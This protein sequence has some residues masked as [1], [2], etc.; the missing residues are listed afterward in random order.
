MSTAPT[1]PWFPAATVHVLRR[2][3]RHSDEITLHHGYDAALGELAAFLRGDTAA[4]AALT[5]RPSA[6]RD[7][8]D[9][10]VVM[11]VYGTGGSGGGVDAP[12]AGEDFH[13]GGFTI[14]EEPVSGPEP[15]AVGLRL[16][17]LRVLDGGT[18]QLSVTYCLEAAGL[19]IAVRSGEN[20]YPAVSITPD[21]H[22]S[23]RPITVDLKNADQ[24]AGAI[25]SP[26]FVVIHDNPV[27]F[28]VDEAAFEQWLARSEQ[29]D[30]WLPDRTAEAPSR[31][32][33]GLVEDAL[34]HQV[35]VGDPRLELQINGDDDSESTGYCVLLHNKHGSQRLVGITSGW[36][37]LDFPVD[38][39]TSL[40]D[41]ARFHLDEVR[42]RANWLLSEI[43]KPA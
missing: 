15:A 3:D 42:N 6:P 33:S 36:S 11:S 39:D 43:Q 32:L 16:A 24:R 37:D 30:F 12:T 31:D 8:S 19:S 27:P 7:L 1:S 35:L 38:K 29:W 26:T 25:A 13:D 22:I 18:D 10:E 5:E 17:V 41:A 21:R 4:A 34:E 2:W 14:T 20:G 23:G 28:S 40:A 9:A